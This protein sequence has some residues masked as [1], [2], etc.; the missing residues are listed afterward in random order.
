[1]KKIMTSALILAM[2]IVFTACGGINGAQMTRLTM[3]T[4]GDSGTYYALGSVIASLIT[5]KNN[6][7][8]ITAIT[9]GASAANCI[10]LNNGDTDLAIMQNDIL[11]YAVNGT[12]TMTEEGPMPKLRAIAS[13]Y[14]EAVQLVALKSSGITTVADLLGKKVCVGDE[15]SGSATNAK[16]VLEAYGL[17][18]EDLDLQYLSFSEACTAMLNGTIDAAFST[19]ALPNNAIVELSAIK[20]IV[21]VPIDGEGATSLIAAYPF[22][23]AAMIGDDVYNVP[24]A[25]TVAMLATLV[26]TEDLS[27]EIVYAITKTLFE[28]RADLV[29]GHIRGNDICLEKAKDGITVDFHPGALKYFKE[30]G[31]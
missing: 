22:Y 12:E 10:A 1:M 17:S 13:M 25:P 18:Y 28:E 21:I 2:I 8:E 23:A 14:P 7:L 31:M 16:Q 15:G 24:G 9:S 5:S 29:S 30:Q 27:K 3:V 11:S 19:S 20:D 6:N 4:G 26:C